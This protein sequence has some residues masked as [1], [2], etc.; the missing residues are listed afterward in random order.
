MQ[1]VTKVKLHFM[2]TESSS[3]THCPQMD[4]RDPT[5]KLYHCTKPTPY[6]DTQSRINSW[7]PAICQKQKE[8]VRVTKGISWS[9][10]G[11]MN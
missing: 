8:M 9:L 2:L 10:R 4:Y 5:H 11:S 6:P 1:L 3:G 7:T